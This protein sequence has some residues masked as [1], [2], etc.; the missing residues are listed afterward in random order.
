[1]SFLESPD[2][3]VFLFFLLL[4]SIGCSAIWGVEFFINHDGSAHLYNAYLMAELLRGNSAVSNFYA[5]NSLSIPN[6][7]GHWF[8]AL[9]LQ[10]FSP[11][12]ATKLIVTILYAG[13]VA[14]VGWLR[15]MTVG[16]SGLKT[17]LLFGATLGFNWM[18]FLGFYNFTFGV[19]GLAIILGIF[20]RWRNDMNFSRAIMLSLGFLLVYFSHLISF[21]IL[22]GSVLVM[23]LS[24]PRQNLKKSFLWTIASMLPIIPI[25]IIYQSMIGENAG[26]GL[27]PNWKSLA[28]PY[29][30]FSWITQIRSSDPFIIISRKTFPF[31][32]AQ[33]DLFPVFT[34]FLWMFVAILFLF[35]ATIRNL[36]SIREYSREYLPFLFAAAGCGLAVMFGPDDFG[37]K[38]G[39][40]L[41]ERVLLCGLIFLVPLFR[42]GLSSRPKV[43]AQLCLAFVFV[44]QSAALWE[45]S[46]RTSE[47]AK[48]FFSASEFISEGQSIA[49]ITII[50]EKFR[51][52]GIPEWQMNNYHGIGKNLTV[53]DNYEVANYVFPVV[54]KSIEDKNFVLNFIATNLFYTA[55]PED[56]LNENL[57]KMEAFL[58]ANSSRIDTMVVWGSDPRVE[59]VL[60]KTFEAEPFFANSKIRLFRRIN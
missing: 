21:A 55:G 14:A 49:S 51:F 26:G 10:F 28:D 53:W 36:A 23:C 37:L 20:F 32:S 50:N 15:I 40:I 35:Y 39:S 58:A 19:I 44:Y 4:I 30:I 54:T 18:W 59:A 1:M 31:I 16:R 17:S 38:H 22:A 13:I 12:T 9:L 45:Y 46:L 34:P 33:S 56:E 52:H 27:S 8:L 57:R 47:S 24:V 11:P 60:Q 7:T 5:L 2:V 6:S 25:L 43:I 3:R 48:A 29:S 41:R 42:T